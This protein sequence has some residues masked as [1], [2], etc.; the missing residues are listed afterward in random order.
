MRFAPTVLGPFQRQTDY[1]LGSSSH[2]RWVSRTPS[3]TL[4]GTLS[5]A[6]GESK[7]SRGEAYL[8]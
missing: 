5:G 3:G 8:H 7:G 4:S 2:P 1:N 6:E